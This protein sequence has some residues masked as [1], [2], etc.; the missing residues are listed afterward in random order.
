MVGLTGIIGNSGIGYETVFQLAS[1]GARVYI[2]AR[3]TQ[4]IDDAISRMKSATATEL[5]LHPLTMDLQN[6]ISVKEAA[7][8]FMKKESRLDIL[9]NNAG[10]MAVPFALTVDGFELQWQTNYLAPFLL[11]KTL[12]P[13]L[14]ST[15]A[16]S[17]S[18]SRVRIINVSGDAALSLGVKALDL[19]RPNLEYLTGKT[20]AW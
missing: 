10:I 5:D 18:P 11:V 20:A 14:K 17:P 15:A 6:M 19:E 3:S 9:I 12:L 1:H 13:I 8:T 7:D 16:T 4:R 2:A